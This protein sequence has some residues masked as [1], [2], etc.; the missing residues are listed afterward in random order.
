MPDKPDYN[1]RQ[2]LRRTIH[3]DRSHQSEDGRYFVPLTL[4]L[5]DEHTRFSNGTRTYPYQTV[6]MID[7]REEYI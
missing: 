7:S 2:E 4:T 5:E 3:W 1:F 6:L